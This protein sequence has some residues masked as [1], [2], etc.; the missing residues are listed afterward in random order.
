MNVKSAPRGAYI[1]K[2]IFGNF[3]RFDYYG[4]NRHIETR[5][6]ASCLREGVQLV[7]GCGNRSGEL[8]R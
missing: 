3:N 2:L 7:Y 8:A 6:D 5:F 4:F 1:L